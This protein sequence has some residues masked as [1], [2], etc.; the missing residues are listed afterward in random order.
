MPESPACLNAKASLDEIIALKKSFD[1]AYDAA[2]LTKSISHTDRAREAK[3]LLEQ[4]ITILR[5]LTWPAETERVLRLREQYDF[6]VSLLKK[7]GLVKTKMGDD[8]KGKMEEVFYIKGIDVAE[9]PIPSY[10]QVLKQI[11][12][13]RGILETKFDQGFTRLL[14]VPFGMGLDDMIDTFRKYILDYKKKHSAQFTDHEPVE[15]VVVW[16]AGYARA[17]VANELVYE[18]KKLGQEH[19]GKTKQMILDEQNRGAVWNAGWR[20]IFVQGASDEETVA[21]IP[22]EHEGGERGDQIK[23]KDIEAGKLLVE[24]DEQILKHLSEQ[25]SPYYGESGMTPE[26]WMMVFMAHLEETGEFLDNAE[27]EA[28]S[29]NAAL[30]GAY[31]PSHDRCACAYTYAFTGSTVFLQSTLTHSLDERMGVRHVVKI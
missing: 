21:Y 29:S 10:S 19:Q 24:Y 12:L 23:R 9:Y 18:P 25:S 17:D 8:G 31:F 11:A 4:K 1:Q 7:T 15:P 27:E 28:R 13:E 20:A 16:E 26:D 14:L 3:E 30:T 5:E 22:R 2:V 6:Q